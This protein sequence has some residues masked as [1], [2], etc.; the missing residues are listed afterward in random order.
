MKIGSEGASEPEASPACPWRTR[1]PHTVGA[2]ADST[3]IL[4]ALALSPQGS[5]TSNCP[6]S[7]CHCCAL[8]GSGQGPEHITIAQ[9]QKPKRFFLSK[10]S[11]VPLQLSPPMRE[12]SCCPIF[13]QGHSTGLWKKEMPL[14]PAVLYSNDKLLSECSKP[15]SHGSCPSPVGQGWEQP[16]WQAQGSASCRNGS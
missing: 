11:H 16:L 5:P 6:H 1:C 13:W 10:H 12:K 2:V 3:G 9:L 14:W 7:Q 15:V 8:A 4:V